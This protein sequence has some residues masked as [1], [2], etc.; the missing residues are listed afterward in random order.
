MKKAT[1]YEIFSFLFGLIGLSLSIISLVTT[2]WRL[3]VN[4][5]EQYGLYEMCM[6]RQRSQCSLVVN[7]LT[8]T[9]YGYRFNR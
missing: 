9:L 1:A 8:G 6:D 3:N 4:T 5:G 2:Q 7:E